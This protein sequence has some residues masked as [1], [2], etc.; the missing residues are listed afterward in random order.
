MIL[1][2]LL[3]ALGLNV[4]LA[5]AA[6]AARAVT[7]DGAVAG[8]VTGFVILYAGGPLGWLILGS[9][10]VSSSLLS[11]VGRG[12]KERLREIHAKDGRRDTVQ[13][14]ANGGVGAAAALFY[15]FYPELPVLAAFLAAF[16]A[17]A[18]DTWGSEIGVLAGR[19][20][21]SILT[22]RPLTT[23]VS[24]GVSL[25]GTLAS[26]AGALFIA[27]IAAVLL[28][29]LSKRYPI[30]RMALVALTAIVTVAGFA[31]SLVD[32]LLGAGFQARYRLPSGGITERSEI[33]GVPNPRVAGLGWMNNDLVNLLSIS[34]ASFLA[35]GATRWIIPA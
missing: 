17:A 23:G 34:A 33:D 14:L 13:V 7:R 26:A 4:S 29:M 35:W 21:R 32:S 20:P 27:L 22:F 1:F 24:G 30:D 12:K 8:A 19:R 6:F 31:G 18:A 28:L 11:R 2:N 9:F 15:L 25:V 3:V 10:F 5:L 16:A